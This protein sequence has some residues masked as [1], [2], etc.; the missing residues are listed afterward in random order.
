MARVIIVLFKKFRWNYIF[1]ITR[2]WL[3]KIF[4]WGTGKTFPIAFPNKCLH[5]SATI[6]G[7]YGEKSGYNEDILVVS[8]TKTGYS[9]YRNNFQTKFFAIGY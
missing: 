7:V 3:Y 1:F 8:L 4:Q 5:V 6:G 2:K 9:T